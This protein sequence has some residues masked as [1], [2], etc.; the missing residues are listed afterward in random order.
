MSAKHHRQ[1]ALCK[2]IQLDLELVRLHSSPCERPDRAVGEAGSRVVE[3]MIKQGER[4]VCVLVSG[5]FDERYEV[6]HVE[7]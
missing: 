4:R 6:E 2:R 7:E 3:E 5:I 1:T